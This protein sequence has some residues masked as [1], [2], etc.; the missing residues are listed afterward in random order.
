MVKVICV[1][2]WL[3]QPLIFSK[4]VIQRNELFLRD[5]VWIQIVRVIFI[6]LDKQIHRVI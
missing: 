4:K 6:V 1:K 3:F 2:L 5:S